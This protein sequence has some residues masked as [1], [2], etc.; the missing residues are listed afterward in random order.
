[1]ELT[2]TVEPQHDD[3]PVQMS[4]GRKHLHQVG[5]IRDARD[6]QVMESGSERDA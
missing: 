1:M 2:A 3:P 4:S 5:A 6:G